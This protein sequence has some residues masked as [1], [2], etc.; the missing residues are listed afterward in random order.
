MHC[1]C[2]PGWRHTFCVANIAYFYYITVAQN[3]LKSTEVESLWPLWMLQWLDA[4]TL[5]MVNRSAP[6]HRFFMFCLYIFMYVC[7]LWHPLHSWPSLEG[8]IPQSAFLK[9]NSL[10]I[11]GVFLAPLGARVRGVV[12]NIWHVQ[13]FETVPVIKGYT[14]TIECNAK[15][16]PHYV[17]H[18][19]AITRLCIR[20]T[21]SRGD[22]LYGLERC[23][24]DWVRPNEQKRVNAV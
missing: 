18:A 10:L 9:I 4:W 5:L 16:E 3:G 24:G 2:C 11:K 23:I 20:N 7:Q 8:G 15:K 13:P 21:G 6:H 12:I 19:D 1:G 14:N 22:Q 17:L